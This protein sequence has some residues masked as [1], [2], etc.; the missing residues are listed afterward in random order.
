MAHDVVNEIIVNNEWRDGEFAKYRVNPHQVDDAL[1]CRMCIPMIYA[2]WE[3][4]VVDSLKLLLAHLNKLNLSPSHTPVN[5]LVLSLGDSY[6]S[7]SG[8]QSFTQRM[9]F[10]EKF[11]QRLQLNIQFQTKINTKSNLKSGILNEICDMFGLDY[12]K[13]TQITP[14]ID[15][16][17]SVR[18]SIAHGENSFVLDKSNIE[19]YITAVRDAIDI[20]LSEINI[21]LES[22]RYTLNKDTHQS[23]QIGA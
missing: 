13:F 20:L 18:N 5:L 9:T 14:D 1:W 7:L 23:S 6:Q 15:R 2:H 17:V 19:R 4:F 11:G 22:K 12:K 3:G 16:L 10:T 8:K 21:F